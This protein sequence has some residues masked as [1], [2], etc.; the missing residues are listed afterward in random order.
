[1]YRRKIL[2]SLREIKPDFFFFFYNIPVL[3]NCKYEILSR[4]EI[5]LSSSYLMHLPSSV[6]GFICVKRGK[7]PRLVIQIARDWKVFFWRKMCTKCNPRASIFKL[8]ALNSRHILIYEE[9]LLLEK[10]SGSVDL[11]D[12][13]F[14]TQTPR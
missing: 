5:Q 8:G 11:L 6:F 7:I 1:M 14:H 3:R 4:N 10:R 2:G 12:R 13:V 9:T